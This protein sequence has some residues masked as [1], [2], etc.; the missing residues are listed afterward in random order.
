MIVNMGLQWAESLLKLNETWYDENHF[1]P[2]PMLHP[3]KKI[4][5]EGK[6]DIAA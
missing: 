5:I 3:N 2:D 4:K 1:L 6:V